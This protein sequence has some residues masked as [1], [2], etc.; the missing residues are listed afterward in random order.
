MRTV[1]QSCAEPGE[2]SRSARIP[3][4]S[5]SA[6]ASWRTSCTAVVLSDTE[7]DERVGVRRVRLHH[8]RRLRGLVGRPG[9]VET[10]SR[11]SCRDRRG[12]GPSS[13]DDARADPNISGCAGGE[14][15]R[16][17]RPLR[18]AE[19]T[20]RRRITA[21]PEMRLDP[22]ADVLEQIGRRVAERRESTHIGLRPGPPSWSAAT[23]MG[24]MPS[25]LAANA[26]IERADPAGGEHVRRRARLRRRTRRGREARVGRRR[27]RPAAGRRRP[28]ARESA[29]R[30]PGCGPCRSPPSTGSGWA[31]PGGGVV[32]AD[33][34]PHLPAFG[35]QVRGRVRDDPEHVVEVAVLAEVDVDPGPGG[36]RRRR[37]MLT[38]R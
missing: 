38:R 21:H 25:C 29:T 30:S 34:P 10:L 11:C 9:S 35:V 7:D 32:R 36:Q 13:L 18:V 22:V 6:R 24:A 4:R 5:A 2:I 23:T 14:L 26:S 16:T 33:R 20:P 31:R 27:A 1:F 28:R 8:R 19:N 12:S 15:H 3:A 37:G 17:G